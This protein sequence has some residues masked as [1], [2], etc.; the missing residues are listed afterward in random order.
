MAQRLNDQAYRANAELFEWDRGDQALGN[1]SIQ[2]VKAKLRSKGIVF[3]GYNENDLIKT[4]HTYI[5]RTQGEFRKLVKEANNEYYSLYRDHL[6][7]ENRIS[8]LIRNGKLNLYL[9][10]Y[11]S[12]HKALN[13]NE[14]EFIQ[15]LQSGTGN[16]IALNYQF[17]QENF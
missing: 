9:D 10:S 11:L 13:R 6:I 7:T 3:R 15:K 2:Y 14:I 4:I 5:R 12:R 1:K 17:I 16:E 8:S